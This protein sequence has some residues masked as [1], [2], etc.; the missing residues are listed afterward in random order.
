VKTPIK[1]LLWLALA[2]SLAAATVTVSAI[3]WSTR[4]TTVYAGG[5]S[6]AAFEQIQAGMALD[7]VYSVLGQ[8]LTVRRE[9]SPA[10]WCYGELAV[11]RQDRADVIENFLKPQNCVLLND[12]GQVIG[13]T[14]D[15]LASARLGMTTQD[16]LRLQGEPTRRKRSSVMT[17]HYSRP[18]GEGLFKARIVAIDAANRVS[19]VIVY[20]FHD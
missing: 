19:D 15:R 7:A 16:V 11:A 3:V 6:E 18:G 4:D 5:F 10:T 12:A 2:L 8:P 14:G 9:A 20:Q 17:L 13:V 1:N